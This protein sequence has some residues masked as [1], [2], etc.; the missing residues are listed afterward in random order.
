MS[1]Y[2]KSETALLKTIDMC[3]KSKQELKVCFLLTHVPNPRMNKR[4]NVYKKYGE[5]S[6]ICTR[7]KSQNIWNPQVEDVE[8]NIFDI[9]LPASSHLFKRA[10]MSQEYQKKALKIL[11]RIKP[12]ILYCG[13]LDSLMIATK[14]EKDN[15]NID[16]IYEVADLRETYIE[17][18]KNIIK[19]LLVNIVKYKERKI[20]HNVKWLVVTSPEFYNKYYYKLIED[21]KMVFVPNAPDQEVFSHYKHKSSGKFTIGFIG[22]IRYLK[23]MKM[24]VDVA[25]ELDCEVLFAGAGGTSTEY[26]EI[27]D[28][29]K[30]R[31]Y[32]TFTGRYDYEKE[33]AEIYGKVDCV[34]AVYDA[35]NPN[36]RIALPNKLYEAIVCELPIIVAN[37]TYL[38]ELVNKWG[39]GCSVSYTDSYELKK[40]IIKLMNDQNYYN[41]FVHACRKIN[42]DFE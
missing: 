20:F 31:K 34:Y 35:S 27:T 29:C 7:R 41:K 3:K 39:V 17:K 24:L 9:D 19:K 38:A 37:G 14:Y 26:A 1:L 42:D 30:D 12:N 4:I 2:N 32:V 18:P 25:G 23:Q 15:E 21:K 22:G 8:Y 6:V 13:G 36:V 28:Y 40:E 10:W 11:R 33:I 16:I 5:V